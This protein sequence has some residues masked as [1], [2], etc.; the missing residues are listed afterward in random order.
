[1]RDL[2]QQRLD[3]LIQWCQPMAVHTAST[4]ARGHTA[5][6]GIALPHLAAVGVQGAMAGLA[7]PIDPLVPGE[8]TLDGRFRALPADGPGLAL[9]LVGMVAVDAEDAPEL[10]AERR[11]GRE[12]LP[13][14]LQEQRR[15]GGRGDRSCRSAAC[16]WG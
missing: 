11:R 10:G 6:M 15:M 2:L 14:N 9:G 8:A 5:N 1:M 4:W 3:G 16:S 13:V 12:D 7:G